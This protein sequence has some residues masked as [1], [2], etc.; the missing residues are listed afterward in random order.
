[1]NTSE[2]LEAVR[3]VMPNLDVQKLG[4]WQKKGYLGTP[5]REGLG[6]G[7]GLSENEWPADTVDRIKIIAEV[8]GQRVTDKAELALIGKGYFI[9]G[10]GAGVL[11]GLMQSLINNCWDSAKSGNKYPVVAANVF[12][13]MPVIETGITLIKEFFP[14]IDADDSH[15]E[16]LGYECNTP[17]LGFTRL[18][19]CFSL[20]NL[21]QYVNDATDLELEQA[22]NYAANPFNLLCPIIA[23]YLGREGYAPVTTLWFDYFLKQADN[24]Q[25]PNMP[26]YEFDC[27]IRLLCV[28]GVLA[29]SNRA[30]VIAKTLPMVLTGVIV[31]AIAPRK[32]VEDEK[33]K[34]SYIPTT[35]QHL[36]DELNA[37]HSAMCDTM[38]KIMS[39]TDETA[40]RL[41]AK[42][43]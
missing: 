22:F 1:M 39:Y 3:D 24:M 40:N 35:P 17:K 21:S 10:S 23:H 8:S 41:E 14:Y 31:A 33:G 26:R 9:G 16:A 30:D 11:R 13:W 29:I 27:V 7:E 2:V 34:A 18:I 4:R 6:R 5:K 38:L 42:A 25:L 28:F 32:L 19:D 37:H 20:D 12:P 43:V 15:H 36:I